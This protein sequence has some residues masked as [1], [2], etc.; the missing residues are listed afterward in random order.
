MTIWLTLHGKRHPVFT[1]A[2]ARARGHSRRTIAR[3]L[4]KK[5]WT[6]VHHGVHIDMPLEDLFPD[7]RHL[8][9]TAAAILASRARGEEWFA[10]GVSAACAHGLPLAGTEPA[11][12]R[13]I[14]PSATPSSWT[15]PT[16]HRVQRP[17]SPADIATG[18]SIPSVGV[19]AALAV[20]ARTSPIDVSVPA[21]DA[22][23]HLHMT[24][25][26]AIREALSRFPGAGIEKARFAIEFAHPGAGSPPESV[27]RVI[28][29]EAGFPP[30]VVQ[31]RIVDDGHVV[32]IAD[33]Y[34]REFNLVIEYDGESKF[35][36]DALAKGKKSTYSQFALQ[37]RRDYDLVVR[38]Y[39]VVH[40][41]KADMNDRAEL[42]RKLWRLCRVA[43]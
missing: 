32:R 9:R 20:M 18:T 34:L 42:V 4:K 19:A 29:H 15:T 21:L 40:I 30:P 1:T 5:T 17:L 8:V 38:G 36:E 13:L 2:D 43:A 41:T 7:E 24:S 31:H 16:T 37:A 23:L 12:V 6:T 10:H 22:A 11:R 3:H 25:K 26:E 27:L 35:D 39:R 14:R 28:L 33:L